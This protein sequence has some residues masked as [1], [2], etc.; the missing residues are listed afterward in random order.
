MANSFPGVAVQRCRQRPSEGVDRRRCPGLFCACPVG[1]EAKRRFRPGIVPENAEIAEHSWDRFREPGCACR[2]NRSLTFNSGRPHF[3]RSR[4]IDGYD[5]SPS[6]QARWKAKRTDDPKRG[7][8]GFNAL[9]CAI[10][11]TL[12]AALA[13][14]AQQPRAEPAGSSRRFTGRPSFQVPS[15]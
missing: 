1:R 2:E 14:A 15:G 7:E 12:L 4:I 13:F 5:L 9:A 3:A 8:D 11:L 10:A 6:N